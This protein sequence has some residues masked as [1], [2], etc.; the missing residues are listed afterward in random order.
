M[1]RSIFD[2]FRA[3]ALAG[4]VLGAIQ[5]EA[6]DVSSFS[7]RKGLL[8]EQTSASLVETN[9]FEPAFFIARVDGRT[10]SISEVSL[11]TPSPIF[12]QVTLDDMGDRFE[13]VVPGSKEDVDSLLPSGPYTFTFDSDNDGF[14]VAQLNLTSAPFPTAVPQIVN[15]TAAQSINSA[16]DFTLNFSPL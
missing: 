4:L 10:A 16:A 14:S 8:L 5:A 7:V 13:Y 9:G 1:M 11:A 15:Y 2:V 6:V 3:G 12:G